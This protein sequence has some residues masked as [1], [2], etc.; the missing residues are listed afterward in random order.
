MVVLK[1]YV[2]H[3]DAEIYIC[4]SFKVLTSDIQSRLQKLVQELGI[5]TF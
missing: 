2:H 3:N 4:I 5:E 1:V